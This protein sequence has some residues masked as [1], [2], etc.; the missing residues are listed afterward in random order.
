[1]CAVKLD[2]AK[3]F[4]GTLPNGLEQFLSAIM[5]E[6]ELV[7][8]NEAFAYFRNVTTRMNELNFSLNDKMAVIASVV[9]TADRYGKKELLNL[10][11]NFMV[12]HSSGQAADAWK[13]VPAISMLEYQ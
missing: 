5:I 7:D 13:N 3:S 11:T 12:S 9:E 1:M 8:D 10:A 2:V 6:V 4:A